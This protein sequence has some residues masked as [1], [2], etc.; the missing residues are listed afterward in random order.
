MN[1]KR[2]S[3]GVIASVVL[4]TSSLSFANE[5]TIEKIKE[6][7]I[8]KESAS[9][10]TSDVNIKNEY[11]DMLNNRATNYSTNSNPDFNLGQTININIPNY[12]YY[13]ANV[14]IPS[15]GLLT[16]TSSIPSDLKGSKQC[17]IVYILNEFGE[18]VDSA[19]L[20]GVDWVG[21]SNFI[22]K[23]GL[24]PGRYEVKF[25]T[26]LENSIST[27]VNLSLTSS[28]NVE[29]EKN[30]NYDTATPINLGTTYMG[31]LNHCDLDVFKV[32]VPKDTRV[33]VIFKETN[34]INK[35]SKSTVKIKLAN[36]S[37]AYISNYADGTYV[38]DI[39]L[40]KG[41]NYIEVFN[42]AA[43]TDYKIKVSEIFGPLMPDIDL[44]GDSFDFV[45]GDTEKGTKV[46]VKVGSGSYARAN[47]RD[48]G[49]FIL[50]TGKIK[51]GTEVRVF[52]K[53]SKGVNSSVAK[54][55]SVDTTP[56][57]DPSIN[58]FTINST[59]VTGTTEARATVLCRI[60]SD[61]NKVY[62]TIADSKGKFSFNVGKL[63][64]G[65]KIEVQAVDAAGNYSHI[66]E[67]RV[68][69]YV[70]APKINNFSQINKTVTGTATKGNTVYTKI[71]G[72]YYSGKADSNGKFKITIP[73]QKY[74]TVLKFYA[75]ASNGDTSVIVSKQ[76][77]YAP[78]KPAV[79]S[80]T[81]KSTKIT[82]KSSKNAN[83]T[84]KIGNK[85][86][87]GKT[88]T[89][90]NFSIAIPKQK[91]GTKITVQAKFASTGLKSYPLTVTV[92]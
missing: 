32:T 41:V 16:V 2:M 53:N 71:G 43:L 52:A 76:V 9:V 8:N 5:T 23:V 55:K 56:P 45:S 51:E 61:Q 6:L 50:K 3:S 44:V 11:I 13:S 68:Q 75:K 54:T 92:K 27:N 80:M 42:D 48:N 66:K 60:N 10:S 21:Q 15:K 31:S 91:K 36:S 37:S 46:Y 79:N 86:Y 34:T 89:N 69:N 84:V 85:N 70:A 74:K 62:E 73:K 1:I 83:I 63:S 28:N 40:K 20:R 14:T 25:G 58:K 29:L 18:I 77:G 78:K 38:K 49:R 24:N 30:D 4:M 88:N 90:G 67:T 12:D 57:K 7:D 19:V 33:K 87:T 64:R 22:Y 17:F 65:I 35:D 81:T 82:G 26:T 47:V 39:I 59:T 72:K